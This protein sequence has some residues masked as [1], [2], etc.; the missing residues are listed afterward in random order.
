M[1][2][3]ILCSSSDPSSRKGV[4]NYMHE[5]AKRLMAINQFE[6][7]RV[8]LIRNYSS[9]LFAFFKFHINPLK[10]RP[11]RETNLFVDSI[12]YQQIWHCNTLWENLIGQKL[13]KKL[14]SR[15]LV[16]DCKKAIGECDV[17]FS[18]KIDSHYVAMN[19]GIPY[20]CTWHGSD[21]NVAPFQSEL[22]RRTTKNVMENAKM[23]FFVSKA[24]LNKS[25]EITV[26]AN[27]DVIYTGP[28]DAFYKYDNTTIRRF[29][30]ERG[31]AADVL[32][33]FVGN[34]I[35][36]KNVLVIPDILAEVYEKL[37]QKTIK[38]IVAGH[39][40]LWSAMKEKLENN[41]NTYDY[42][43]DVSPEKMPSVMNCLDILLLPSKNEGL[44]LVTLEALACGVNVVASDVGGISELNP[45][46]R[47]TVLY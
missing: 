44:P 13:Q 8:F 21:I 40:A 39:G 33:G 9:R 17:I 36:I 18:H 2:V 15:C 26:N 3:A 30:E 34:I 24:L 14:A 43:G 31:W 35:D 28:S 7:V 47:K 23:N 38:L 22:L 37:P 27:K 10:R 11:R 16:R 20:V 46:E 32:I 19:L 4:L 12:T 5:E 45:L 42:M 25:E 6:L 1:K 29:K 41:K